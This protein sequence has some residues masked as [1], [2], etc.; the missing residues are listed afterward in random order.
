MD[1]TLHTDLIIR[2]GLEV[3]YETDT[4]GDQSPQCFPG[5]VYVLD[6]PGSILRDHIADWQLEA[7]DQISFKTPEKLF[8]VIRRAFKTRLEQENTALLANKKRGKP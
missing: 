3:R 7:T 2:F 4:E 5:I 6:C 8:E 1:D